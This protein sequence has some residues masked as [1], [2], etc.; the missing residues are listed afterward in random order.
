VPSDEDDCSSPDSEKGYIDTGINLFSTDTIDKDF[1][2]EFDVVSVASGN[3]SLATLMNSYN[4]A[5]TPNSGLIY[6]IESSNLAFRVIKQDNT[7]VLKKEKSGAKHIKIS[8]KNGNYYLKTSEQTGEELLMDTT[9]FST[10]GGQN[11]TFGSSTDQNGD[12]WRF[13]KGTLAN[14]TIKLEE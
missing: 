7:F 1:T 14:M 6:R 3:T 8:R 10:S 12:P 2:I 4:E 13:F 9:N 11:V 5:G